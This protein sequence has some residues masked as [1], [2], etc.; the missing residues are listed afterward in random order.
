MVAEPVDAVL[1]G[2]LGLRSTGFGKAEI[3][4]A[5]VGRYMRLIV[6]LEQR[7]RPSGTRPFGEAFAPPPVILW[8]GMILRQVER[9]ESWLCFRT[10]RNFAA[11]CVVRVFILGVMWH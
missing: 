10:G 8:N 6:I 4:K 9:D 2:K 11:T 7:L 3:V 1:L 5:K